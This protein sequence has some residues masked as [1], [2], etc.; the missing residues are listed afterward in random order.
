MAV[1]TKVAEMIEDFTSIHT[2]GGGMVRQM[3]IIFF[4][5]NS[6]VDKLFYIWI[7]VIQTTLACKNSAIVFWKLW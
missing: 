3:K 2:N 4:L 1:K 6:N 5:N 7:S